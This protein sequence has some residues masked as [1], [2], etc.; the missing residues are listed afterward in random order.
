MPVAP[1][2]APGRPAAPPGSAPEH[3]TALAPL[4]RLL[5]TA[6]ARYLRFVAA[7]SHFADRAVTQDQ[8][9]FAVW[10]ESNLVAATAAWALREDRRFVSFSTRGFR[11]IMMNAMLRSMGSEVIT[12]P[13]EGGATRAEAG[14]MSLELARMAAAGWTLVVSCDG[15]FGPYRQAK[16][17]VLLVARESGLPIQPWAVA[18]RPAL[19]L[20]GRWDRH[21]VPL[22]FSRFRVVEGTQIR[23]PARARL[24]PL[25]AQLQAELDRIATLAD[26]RMGRSGEG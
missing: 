21:L 1:R 5:G 19:R 16:P 3:R 18:I 2:P 26:A 22:P 8:I 14:R 20:R 10:H 17:G 23:V 11:G 24:K 15:P 4:A 12:L 6:L 7:T 25:L 13:D 9:V